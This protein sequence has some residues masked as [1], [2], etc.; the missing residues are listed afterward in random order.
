ME[1]GLT[2]NVREVLMDM[3]K[4]RM[5]LI[6]TADQLRFSYLAILEGLHQL[7]E[8]CGFKINNFQGISLCK[9]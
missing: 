9:T 2:V 1:E 5:G 7:A 6:Q 4:F 8:V 3:R